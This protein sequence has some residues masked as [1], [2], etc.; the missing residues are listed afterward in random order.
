VRYVREARV[1]ITAVSERRQ[2]L[3]EE[4]SLSATLVNLRSPTDSGS[5]HED[6]LS[7]VTR[8]QP[9]NPIVTRQ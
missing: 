5:E 4:V 2:D 9:T 3:E 7:D 1:D 8:W 6:E